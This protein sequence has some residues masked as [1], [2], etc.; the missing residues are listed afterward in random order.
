MKGW[1]RTEGESKSMASSSG[2]S[3]G[4][5]TSDD[6]DVISSIHSELVSEIETD[7]YSSSET[8]SESESLVPDIEW[9]PSETYSIQEQIYRSMAALMYQRSQF[10]VIR[11]VGQPAVTMKVDRVKRVPMT[12]EFVEAFRREL[13]E[14]MPFAIPHAQ[15]QKEIEKRH[16]KLRQLANPREPTSH[17]E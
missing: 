11:R 16:E 15:A 10:A 4:E 12:S 2:Y 9:L 5:S 14:S 6:G 1:S 7:G 3:V 8:E 17:Y 13:F